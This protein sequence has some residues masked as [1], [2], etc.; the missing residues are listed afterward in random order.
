[1][2]AQTLAK[3]VQGFATGGLVS[4]TMP[5]GSIDRPVLDAAA[6]PTRTVRVELPTN[7]RKVNAQIDERD[8]GRLLQLLQSTQMRA[9]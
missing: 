5:R 9:A 2:P 6:G 3:G 1:M 4:G 8:E 7:G